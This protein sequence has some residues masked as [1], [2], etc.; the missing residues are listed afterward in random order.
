MFW[1]GG[2]FS[3]RHPK[4]WSYIK[5]N[6]KAFFI[7][8]AI[9]FVVTASATTVKILHSRQVRYK[10]DKSVEQAINELYEKADELGLI[11]GCKGCTKLEYLEST[12][13]QYIDTE[14]KPNQTT[15]VEVDGNFTR[16]T[17]ASILGANPYFVITSRRGPSNYTFRYNNTMGET[18]FNVLNRVTITLDK[19]G[20]YIN[21]SLINT[22]SET[23][24]ES[25]NSI[26]LFARSSYDGGVEERS[27]SRIYSCKI[28]DDGIL[29]RDFIPVLESNNKPCMFDKVNKKCYYSKVNNDFEFPVPNSVL[30]K[31][32]ELKYIETTGTQYIATDYVFKN[33]PKVIGEIMITSDSDL[34]IM[35]NAKKQVGNF[36]IDF[37]RS[38]LFYRYSSTSSTNFNTGI[39]VGNW[40]NFEFS[41]KVIVDGVEKGSIS[42]YDFSNNDQIFLIGRGRNFGHARFKE[43]KM[44]DGDTLVRD[45]VPYYKKS[46]DK[47][48]MLDKVNNVFYENEGTGEF[49]FGL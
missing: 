10:N 7:T 20:S 39:I 33:K 45:L 13:T 23:S 12:G 4:L 34:D 30:N 18:N 44:Y 21:G 41:D 46:I 26:L 40:Y 28:W 24:F 11:A 2:N 38:T 25:P 9:T 5:S 47:I 35:G 16:S 14:Y 6:V 43:I 49:L 36:I 8:G 29:V 19:T 48:G 17:G 1:G 32:I 27:N 37:L 31:D 3:C 15:K 42:T 22:F